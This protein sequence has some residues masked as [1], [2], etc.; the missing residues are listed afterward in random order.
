MDRTALKIRTAVNQ[1]EEAFWATI[2]EFF[3]EITTGDLDPLTSYSLLEEMK[4]AVTIWHEANSPAANKG[5]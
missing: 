2:S 5:E 4:K 3:P 1:A